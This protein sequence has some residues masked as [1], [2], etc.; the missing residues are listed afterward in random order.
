MAK[1]LAEKLMRIERDIKEYESSQAGMPEARVKR[2]RA[3]A[4]GYCRRAHEEGNFPMASTSGL[5]RYRKEIKSTKVP[6]NLIR[7]LYVWEPLRLN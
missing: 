4:A 7:I 3:K 5:R 6:E 2:N 1:K